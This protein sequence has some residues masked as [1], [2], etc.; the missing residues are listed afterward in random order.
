MRYRIDRER[1]R[2]EVQG[3]LID[4]CER[5]LA[6]LLDDAQITGAPRY[7]NSMQLVIVSN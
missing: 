2:A 5:A 7:I 3:N 4:G 6:I 1:M